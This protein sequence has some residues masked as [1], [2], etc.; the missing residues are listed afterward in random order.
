M[1]QG[2]GHRPLTHRIIFTL[3][4]FLCRVAPAH[5]EKQCS[6]LRIGDIWIPKSAVSSNHFVRLNIPGVEDLFQ[7]EDRLL[8]VEHSGSRS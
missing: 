4:P 5:A 6:L 8:W 3:P 1:E 7:E 2:V